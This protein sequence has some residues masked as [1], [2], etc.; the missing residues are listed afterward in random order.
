M[1]GLWLSWVLCGCGSLPVVFPGDAGSRSCSPEVSCAAPLVCSSGE[2]VE[3]GSDADCGAATPACDPITRRCVPCRGAVG[4]ASPYVCSPSA[5]VCVLPC[6]DGNGCPG[7]IESCR[8]NVC[9]ACNDAEDCASGDLCD[10]PH[11]RCVSCLSDEDCG[12]L[13]PRCNQATGRC[14]ACVTNVD[15]AG[16]S[17]CFQGACRT[18]Y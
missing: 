7:F 5:P 16:G 6:M 1:R 15:C 2:C 12:G 11:G 10:V 14:E 8:S 13:E 3:C 18:P 4:C 17:V 9:S